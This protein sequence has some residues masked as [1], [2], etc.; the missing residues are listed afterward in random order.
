MNEVIA[1]LKNEYGWAKQG[2]KAR[3]NAFSM[4][5]GFTR[6]HRKARDNFIH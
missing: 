3:S 2:E 6:V 4:H 1:W 5:L